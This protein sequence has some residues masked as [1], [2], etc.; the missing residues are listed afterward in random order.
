MLEEA[1]IALH[2]LENGHWWYVGARR[3]YRRLLDIALGQPSGALRV[4]D[5]G[6]GSGGNLEIF[7]HYGPT[8]GMDISGL[9]LQLAPQRPQ[10]GLVQ[11]SATALPFASESFDSV[12]LMGVIEHLEDDVGALQEAARVCRPSGAV[13]LLTSAFPI[14]WS[15]HDEANLHKRRYRA[16]ELRAKLRA[17]GLRPVRLTY[18][19]FFVFPATL[20]VRLLQRRA[21]NA[22]RY[23]MGNPPAWLNSLLIQLIG[24]ESWLLRFVDFPFGVDLIAIVRPDE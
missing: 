7:E 5:A 11:A 13:A 3:V 16:Q 4:L 14:L 17:A 19:N 23:D 6:C 21:S 20:L 24:V 15:H 22:P 2:E 12:N 8:V 9:A 10:L 1:H 18:Q